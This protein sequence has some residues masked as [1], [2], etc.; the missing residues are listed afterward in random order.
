MACLHTVCVIALSSSSDDVALI[1]RQGCADDA[2]GCG[3][4]HAFSA[5]A[6][7]NGDN[8]HSTFISIRALLLMF[9][10]SAGDAETDDLIALDKKW[11]ESGIKGDSALATN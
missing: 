7:N 10:A 9:A 5:S 6:P 2:C 8:M 3:R 11:G 1:N 4:C